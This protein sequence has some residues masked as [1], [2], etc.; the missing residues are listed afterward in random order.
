MGLYIVICVMHSIM[1]LEYATGFFGL[2]T[3]ERCMESSEVHLVFSCGKGKGEKGKFSKGDGAG[4]K[5]GLPL[6]SRAQK[7]TAR[8]LRMLH[9]AWNHILC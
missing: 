2:G 6:C 8:G 9:S 5:L 7:V 4:E 3:M 1:S